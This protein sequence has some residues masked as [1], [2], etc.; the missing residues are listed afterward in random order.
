MP[1]NYILCFLK[2]KQLHTVSESLPKFQ[3]KTFFSLTPWHS[4]H[5]QLFQEQLHRKTELHAADT[6]LQI[7]VD[8]LERTQHKH[9][10][11]L[12]KLEQILHKGEERFEKMKGDFGWSKEFVS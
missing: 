1:W 3:L 12:Q 5:F 2:T 4:N 8:L 6:E 11:C 10:Q 9:E 7:Q